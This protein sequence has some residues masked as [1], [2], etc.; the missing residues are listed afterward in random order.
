[1]RE[2]HNLTKSI[3]T[4][5]NETTTKQKMMVHFNDDA[6]ETYFVGDNHSNLVR[7]NMLWYSAE[8]YELFRTDTQCETK[9]TGCSRQ[10]VQ[11]LLSQ[12]R[13]HKAIGISDPKGLKMLSKVCSK[14]ERL[15]ARQLAAKNEQ[16]VVD[17]L[18]RRIAIPQKR[19]RLARNAVSAVTA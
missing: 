8:E 1:M 18:E 3:K 19:Y 2:S 12:Q 9:E 13:E 7:P 15:R 16:D 10:F 5:M 17:F 11:S 14:G 4:K 6:T